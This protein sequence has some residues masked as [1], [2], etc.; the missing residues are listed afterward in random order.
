MNL[1]IC[2]ADWLAESYFDRIAVPGEV[3]ILFVDPSISSGGAFARS[4]D[5]FFCAWLCGI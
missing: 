3:S 2:T 5:R 1:Y 4:A